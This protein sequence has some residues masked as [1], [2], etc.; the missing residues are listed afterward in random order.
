MIMMR[1]ALQHWMYQN[2]LAENNSDHVTSLHIR[3]RNWYSGHYSE[4]AQSVFTRLFRPRTCNN[5]KQL[6]A[7]FPEVFIINSWERKLVSLDKMDLRRP[8]I[9]V[10]SANN[11]GSTSWLKPDLRVG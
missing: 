5:G 10:H 4:M 6:A 3:E 7:Q 8:S 2:H 1:R 9:T 11:P